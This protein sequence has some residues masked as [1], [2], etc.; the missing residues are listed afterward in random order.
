MALKVIT[1]SQ[2]KGMNR[3]ADISNMPPEYAYDIKNG[4]IDKDN[5]VAKRKGFTKL[6]STGITDTPNILSLFEIQWESGNTEIIASYSTKLGKYNSANGT[7]DDIK[8]GL[9]DSQL[10]DMTMF[11]D[12]AYFCNGAENLQYTEGGTVD[13]MGGTPPV[14]FQFL[15]THQGRVWGARSDSL[16]VYYTQLATFDWTGGTGATAS[17]NLDLSEYV[18]EGDRITGLATFAKVYLVIFLRYSIAIYLAGTDATAFTLQQVIRNIGCISNRSIQ[19]VGDDLIFASDT[20]IK[21][22]S[23]T[24]KDVPVDLPGE[25]LSFLIDPYYRSL[26]SPIL[27]NEDQEQKISIAF[28]GKRNQLWVIIPYPTSEQTILIDALDFGAWSRY[29]SKVSD[30]AHSILTTRDG[31]LY[32]GGAGY[33]YKQDNGTNDIGNSIDFVWSTGH[34]YTKNPYKIMK[35]R[36]IEP[37][38]KYS[39]D[40]THLRINY[41]YGIDARSVSQ[42][43]LD[44]TLSGKASFWDSAKWDEDYWDASGASLKKHRMAGH[45]KMLQLTFSNDYA[46]EDISIYN[47]SLYYKEGGIKL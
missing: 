45:G 30:W 27:N 20:G 46:D 26:I 37:L 8:T 43:N 29:T 9:S 21:S 40:N 24:Q 32:T 7:I 4:F 39:Q 22:L 18:P 38:L 3:V 16:K 25:N 10:F 6:N 5:A 12:T 28:Y 1:Y 36:Y 2:N 14:N 47:W 33:I 15:H 44:L 42:N 19:Q 31:T 13:A 34:L 41:W 11:S 23:A 17:G 35:M